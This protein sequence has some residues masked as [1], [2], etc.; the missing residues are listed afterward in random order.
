MVD[1]PTEEQHAQEPQD[2]VPSTP[3]GPIGQIGTT[4]STK[5]LHRSAR[6]R[7]VGAM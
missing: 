2:T 5:F 1:R 3:N 7:S 4:V 6:L